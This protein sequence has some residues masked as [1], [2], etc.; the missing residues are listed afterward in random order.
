MHK[1]FI[2]YQIFTEYKAV[3]SNWMER[4]RAA[5]PELELYEGADQPGLF[6]EV[7]SGLSRQEYEL[8]KAVRLQSERPANESS[9]RLNFDNT[10]WLQLNQWVPGGAA[11]IHIWYFEK[12]R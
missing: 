5:Y 7:W 11:K 4:V 1:T 6:V 2:E 8:L 9:D 3:Y 12:V 10:D